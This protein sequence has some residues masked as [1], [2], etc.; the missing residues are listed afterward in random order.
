MTRTRSLRASFSR[1]LV[2]A[3]MTLGALISPAGAAPLDQRIASVVA[4]SGVRGISS[5]YVWDQTTRD[6]IYASGPG[7]PVAPASTMKL[8]T[9]A[10]A[11]AE[12]GPEH[13]FDTKVA[14]TGFATGGVWNGNVWL[15]G[16]GDPSLSTAG[17]ARDNYGGA[18]SNIAALVA[19]LRARGITSV[20]GRILVDDSHLDR[21]RYVREWPSRFRFEET[22]A[23]GG[24]TVNQSLVGRYVGSASTRA[25]DIRAG[26]VYKDLLERSGID[27]AGTT[28]SSTVP[29]T[30]EIA[31]S[32][33]SP[34]LR[35]L[36]QHMNRSSDN[37]YAEILLKDIG[38]EA[39][40]PSSGTT[41]DGRV[42]A[43]A[44][45]ASLG[46]DMKAVTWHDGSGLAYG[47]R[48]SARVLG[49]VLGVGAQATWGPYWINSLARSGGQGTLHKRMRTRPY[50]GRVH[51]KTGT[52]NHVSA[53]AGFSERLSGRRYGFAVV[54]YSSPG[55]HISTN[56]AHSLQ[57]RIAMILVR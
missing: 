15:I 25:P 54:T 11:L 17:F 45:L 18:G 1:A 47:N 16:G 12:F 31:G 27:V 28:L 52:L 9:S 38:R 7:R 41:S 21:M 57:D 5:V 53:L 6:V 43:R 10:A 22:G 8:L 39:G 4:S 3:A 35:V 46:V 29:A 36:L 55:A 33:K 51:A 48:V 14:L 26:D 2:L 42:A 30:A 49:H 50:R 32:V 23:L 44:K 24:L 13:T 34:P 20:T 56:A 40:G 37:F 19:P